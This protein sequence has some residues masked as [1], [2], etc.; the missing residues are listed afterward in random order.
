MLAESICLSK[1]R[2]AHRLHRPTWVLRIRPC[3][4]L[5]SL[6][7]M[8]SPWPQPAFA[9]LNERCRR[10]HWFD[11]TTAQANKGESDRLAL[12]TAAHKKEPSRFV[13]RPIQLKSPNGYHRT[14]MTHDVL[15]KVRRLRRR[16]RGNVVWFGGR[17]WNVAISAPDLNQEW[18]CSLPHL[19]VPSLSFC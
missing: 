9:A 14:C 13:G 2:S 8:T 5:L 18:S 16:A 19:R 11:P 7:R 6:R 4:G 1:A 3:G 17:L 12:A 10:Y 15:G